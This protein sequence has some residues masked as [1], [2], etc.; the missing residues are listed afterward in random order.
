[1]TAMFDDPAARVSAA[2]CSAGR[3]YVARPASYST[4]PLTTIPPS[5]SR[6]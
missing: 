6:T 4:T 2:A 3:W 1:M 5:H